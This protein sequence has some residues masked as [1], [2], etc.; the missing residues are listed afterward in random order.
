MIYDLSSTHKQGN[1]IKIFQ[2]SD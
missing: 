2:D 1:R